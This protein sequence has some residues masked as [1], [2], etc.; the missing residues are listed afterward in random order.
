MP[1]G[2]VIMAVKA[3]DGIVMVCDSRL[4]YRSKQNNQLLAYQDGVP[5]IFPLKKFAIGITGDFSDGTSLIKKIVT[6]FDK[7]NPTYRTPEECS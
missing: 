7:S 2:A 4:A 3:K 1:G 5:K 6:D